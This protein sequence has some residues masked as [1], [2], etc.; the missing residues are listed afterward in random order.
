ML[1]KFG[2]PQGAG[3]MAAAH[4]AAQVRK[5][6]NAFKQQ[7]NCELRTWSFRK[8]Y[9]HWIGVEVPTMHETLFALY[10][11]DTKLFMGYKLLDSDDDLV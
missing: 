7:T 8:D 9:R 3:G 10:M 6:L 1:V 2:L 11:S 5:H 4:G